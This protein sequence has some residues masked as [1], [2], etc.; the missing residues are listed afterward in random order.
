[1]AKEGQGGG[2]R[3]STCGCRNAV[4]E[5]KAGQAE[6]GQE[7]AQSGEGSETQAGPDR[8]AGSKQRTAGSAQ[9]PFV[10]AQDQRSGLTGHEATVSATSCSESGSFTFFLFYILKCKNHF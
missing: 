8:Q 1:M 4:L 10:R 2:R 6:A 7:E 9:Q 3:E 5:G